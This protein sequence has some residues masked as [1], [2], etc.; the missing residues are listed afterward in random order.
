MGE[1]DSLG[2]AFPRE[3]ERVRELLTLYQTIPTGAFGAM[4]LK[5]VLQRAEQAAAGGD[6]VAM[7]GSFEELK[8]CQ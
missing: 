3:Q 7:L 5:G 2:D 6:V 1:P 8:G 4:M